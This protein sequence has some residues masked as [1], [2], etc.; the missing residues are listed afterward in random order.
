MYSVIPYSLFPSTCTCGMEVKNNVSR[1][2]VGGIIV[3]A[4]GFLSQMTSAAMLSVDTIEDSE[5]NLSSP[6]GAV[7]NPSVLARTPDCGQVMRWD[8]RGVC[9]QFSRGVSTKL[10]LP[11]QEESHELLLEP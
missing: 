2:D 4:L 6:S 11:P 10:R 3:R 9:S 5:T 7:C 1:R 8:R